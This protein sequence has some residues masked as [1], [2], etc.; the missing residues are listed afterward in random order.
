MI[1]QMVY[2]NK[3]VTIR[4]GFTSAD[5][6]DTHPDT[7]HVTLDAQRQGRVIF[8]TGDTGSTIEGL[9]ITGG[10][11]NGLGGD[12]WGY[13]AGGGLLLFL[14]DR[15][16]TTTVSNNQVFKNVAQNGGG[17]YVYRG[18]PTLT[19]N[20]VTSN[21]ANGYGGGLFLYDSDATLDANTVTSNTANGGGGGL[22]LYYS[23]ATL[24]ANL[25]TSNTANSGGGGL[26]LQGGAVT[27]TNNVV[28]DNQA[29][30]A[31]SGLYLLD[32]SPRL[33]HSTIARNR[34][35]DGSGLYV[36]GSSNR[37]VATL[38]DTILVSHT[39]GIAV[40]AGN[41]AMLESTLW[42]G[43]AGNWSG[44][45]DIAHLND[46]DGDPAFAADGYHLTAASAAISKGVDAEVSV[47]IDGEAR[48]WGGGFDI[49]ADEFD[50]VKPRYLYLPLVL[51]K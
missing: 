6:A 9:Y 30:P 37:S 40:T 8:V 25:V 44:G 7:N 50:S 4:V 34:G 48:P 38:I 39:V 42:Y 2:I 18:A 24:Q 21:T 13:D 12:H 31:G 33:L 19:A 5:W 17:L 35:G 43:N 27:L 45:G 3:A 46:H 29:N 32:T 28:T 36:T 41:M 49:G 10:D 26:F 15:D 11:A 51:R 22:F 23:D 47:D 20:A 1:T 14:W 16:A